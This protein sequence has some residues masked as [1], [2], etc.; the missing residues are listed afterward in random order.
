MD[1]PSVDKEGTPLDDKTRHP[2]GCTSPLPAKEKSF[3]R[4]VG[5]LSAKE[6][7]R[8]ANIYTI[9]TKVVDNKA[10][11]CLLF[12]TREGEGERR[13]SSKGSASALS[14]GRR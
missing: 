5:R 14:L 6:R 1:F 2:A 8:E 13:A 9:L 4:C 7:L 10:K 11:V 3:L 12:V